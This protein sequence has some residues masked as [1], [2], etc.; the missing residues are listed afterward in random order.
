[1]NVFAP[2]PDPA[3]TLTFAG[4]SEPEARERITRLLATGW[5]APQL[6][7]MFGVR[8]EEIDRLARLDGHP[9]AET[10]AEIG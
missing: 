7:L 1:M 4:W 10:A 6:A 8:L 9:E 2:T 3:A 5:R